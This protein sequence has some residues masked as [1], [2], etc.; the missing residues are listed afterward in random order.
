M[1]RHPPFAVRTRLADERMP[2]TDVEVVVAHTARATLRVGDVFLK[3]DPDERGIDNEVAAMAL[4]PVPTP[5]VLWRRHPVLAISAVPGVAL[6]VLEEPS[7][8]PP[9][10]W[11]AAGAAIRALHDAP[12]PS[13]DGATRA[14]TTARLDAECAAIIAE[15]V[16]EPDLVTA[17]RRI[18]DLAL[19]S[20]TPVFAHGDLQI[21]HV[22]WDGERVSGIIDWSA[23]GVGDAHHDLATLTLGHEENLPDLLAGYGR[24]IDED[25]VRSWWSLRSLVALRW[26]LAHGFDAFAPGAEADVLRAAVRRAG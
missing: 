26:L 20:W 6:G 14:A 18:A 22:F 17:N 19:R 1:P 7:T 8:A 24:P 21:T 25:I 12:L 15:G 23:A 16:L 10:A 11:R 3:V 4:A 9:A 5:A 13:W 2:V